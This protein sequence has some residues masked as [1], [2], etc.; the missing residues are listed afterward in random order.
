[1][2]KCGF[3]KGLDL[4]ASRA[5]WD[6]N[7]PRPLQWHVWYPADD[8][9]VETALVD[10]PPEH[11][12]I[13]LGNLALDAPLNA[14]KQRWPV[15]L[16]S[17]GTGGTAGSIGWLARGLATRG[18]IVLAVNHHG[19]TGIERYR[20]EGFLCW[21]ERAADLT[22]LL[23]LFAAK[24]AFADHLDLGHIFAAGYSLGAYAVL[25]LAGA[26][27]SLGQF[28]TWCVD[29]PNVQ[30]APR[31][32]PN[33]ASE[34]SG[35]MASSIA[36]QNSMER[37]T[38]SYCDVR[39][40]AIVAFAPP[41]PVRSLTPASLSQLIA[42]VKLVASKGDNQAPFGDGA[43]WLLAQ[44]HKFEICLLDAAVGHYSFIGLPTPA[45]ARHM[46]ELFEDAQTVDRA[47]LHQHCIELVVQHFIKVN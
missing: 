42:P 1:M 7:G 40:K 43:Q 12:L 16:L 44:N 17:H 9:C 34:V 33:L 20:A 46:P 35:L 8:N 11:A 4:D 36:F 3:Q 19:N 39:I 14:S 47:L 38:Q 6:N 27:T 24:P 28:D 29:N 41:P 32:F 5:N 10:G 26:K 30:Q 22:V 2:Y 23:D 37:H 18:F 25:A 31:E 21:W 15:V 45:G 13:R